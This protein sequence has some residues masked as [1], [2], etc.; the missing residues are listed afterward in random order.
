MTPSEIRKYA[1]DRGVPLWLIADELGIS[2]ATMTRLM[3]HDLTNDKETE[4]LSAIERIASLKKS[5]VAAS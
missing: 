5:E 4:V 3:R 1:K 2:E